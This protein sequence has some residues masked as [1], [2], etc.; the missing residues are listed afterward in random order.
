MQEKET[1]QFLEN[2]KY[3]HKEN[4]NWFYDFMN[5]SMDHQGAVMLNTVVH[6]L[7]KKTII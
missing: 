3:L 1:K 2:M 5:V 7:K 6:T 4:L